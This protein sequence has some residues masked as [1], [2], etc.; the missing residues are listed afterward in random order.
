M[1]YTYATSYEAKLKQFEFFP[2]KFLKFVPRRIPNYPSHGIDHSENIIE[3]LNKFI[4]NWQ[5]EL[6]EK[7]AYLLYLGAWT[8]DIGCIVD[9]KNHNK[10]SARIIKKTPYF[11]SYLGN[12]IIFPLQYVVESH[13]SSYDLENIP[14]NYLEIRLQLICSIFRLLDA[15]EIVSTKCP[16]EVYEYIKKSLKNDN[17]KYWLGHMNIIGVT[18][19]VPE[20]IVQVEKW[21]GSNIIINH[22][23]EEIKSI[24]GVFHKNEM[25]IPTVKKECSYH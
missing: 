8:H 9:R 18:F 1:E 11:Y 3:L 13:S 23:K 2:Q 12:D 24:E 21:N 15:C 25:T 19:K 5:I 14:E 10:I 16:N 17:Q 6:S 22:M 4:S 7:E 20:I